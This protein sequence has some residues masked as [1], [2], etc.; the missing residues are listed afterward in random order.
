MIVFPAIDLKDGKCVRLYKGDMDKSTVFNDAPVV[1]AK[2]FEQAGFDW[3]HIVDLNGAFKGEAVNDKVVKEILQNVNIPVQLGGG[4][5]N[6]EAIEHWLELGVSRVILGTAA[7]KNPELVREACNKYPNRI[8][9]GIDAKNG[10]VA[11]DGWSKVSSVNAIELAQKF[12]D[13]G[14]SAIIYTDINRDGTLTGPDLAGTRKLAKSITIDVI[15]SGGVS[16]LSDIKKIAS[17]EQDGVIGVVV[18]RALYD[19]KFSLE[20]LVKIGQN[21]A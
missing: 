13:M 12:E 7:V 17:L 8:V 3:L 18:G 21:N 16:S 10:M 1:Q 2:E 6:I 15:A 9:V 20:D 5:R 19:K 11:V 4:I 14:V